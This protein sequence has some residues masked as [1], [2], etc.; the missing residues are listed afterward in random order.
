MGRKGQGRK[1][2]IGAV[3]LAAGLV[4]IG[5]GLSVGVSAASGEFTTVTLTSPTS[6]TS[7]TFTWSYSFMQNGGHDLSNIAIHFC[8]QAVLG[9]VVSA[10][11]N[12]E[13]FTSGDVP[14]GHAGF[15]PGIKFDVTTTTGTLFATFDQPYAAA[16]NG[17]FVQSHSGD[18]QQGDAVKSGEGPVCDPGTTTTTT[19]A[20]TT[21]TL[22]T[23]TTTKPSTTTTTAFTT[24]TTAPGTTTTTIGGGTTTVPSTTTTTTAATTATSSTTSTT[25]AGPPPTAFVLGEQETNTSVATAAPTGRLATTGAGS[26]PLLIGLGILLTA[27]GL[28]LLVGEYVGRVAD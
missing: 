28:G 18:G 2:R 27:V 20:T 21:T 5:A 3:M 19:V 17:I 16:P 10:S 6:G 25:L 9:H 4:T 14:G 7:T 1:G 22:A 24:T 23:T 13:V 12:A 26:V 11:P 8:S 15:G